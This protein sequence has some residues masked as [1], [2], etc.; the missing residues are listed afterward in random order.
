MRKYSNCL[1]LLVALVMSSPL[2]LLT[3]CASAPAF[4]PSRPQVVITQATQTDIRKF[5]T[6]YIDNPYM[7]P[8]TL[9]RGK[10]NE[11]FVVKVDFNIPADSKVSILAEAKLVGGKEAARVHDAYSFVEFWDSLT[12]TES[13]KGAEVQRKITTIERSCIP[14]F[15]FTQ[16]AGQR[17]LYIPFSGPNPILRPATIYVQIVVGKGEPFT[18]TEKLL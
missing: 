17:T 12:L 3:G 2:L 6:S 9:L 18:F 15:D 4:D 10:L 7:E 11:F 14:A 8:R 16:R 1:V 13:E 5:G